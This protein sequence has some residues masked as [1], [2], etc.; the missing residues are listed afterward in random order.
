VNCTLGA[1]GVSAGDSL[2]DVAG[3]A[4][5][6]VDAVLASGFQDVTVLD[7]PAPGMQ[8]GR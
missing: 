2:I 6:Q 4:S 7:I 3:R 5:A 1:A 8:P